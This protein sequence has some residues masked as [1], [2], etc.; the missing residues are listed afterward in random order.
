[1]IRA[2]LSQNSDSLFL[3]Q[4][5]VR[6]KF[7]LAGPHIKAS[8]L[9]YETNFS[10]HITIG[11][12][13]DSLAFNLAWEGIQSHGDFVCEAEINAVSLVIAEADDEQE[14]FST[15]VAIQYSLLPR[16]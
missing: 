11:R 12:H 8:F 14:D 3:L 7:E 13:L 2:E 1:M 5:E 16:S 4:R 10:P 6:E 15:R 9:E